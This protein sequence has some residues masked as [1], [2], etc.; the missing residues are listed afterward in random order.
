MAGFLV[1]Y[2]GIWIG[3][4]IMIV[5]GIDMVALADH[6]HSSAGVAAAFAMA[7]VWQRTSRKR[8]AT[9]AC[10]RT[11]PLAARGWRA[12]RD[13]LKYGSM[14]GTHCVISC[15]ALMLACFMAHSITTMICVAA[16]AAADRY[17]PRRTSEVIQAVIP[18]LAVAWALDSLSG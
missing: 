14:I 13:S 10:H 6:A 3:A 11:I 2:L 15:W 17:L 5:I 8:R 9:N 18:L 16:V 12:S 4:G 7:A 1:G